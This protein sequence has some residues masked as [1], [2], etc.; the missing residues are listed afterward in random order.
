MLLEYSNFDEVFVVY[1]IVV[2]I[3]V[4]M[5]EGPYAPWHEKL[6]EREREDGRGWFYQT[7]FNLF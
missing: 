6:K 4:T 3:V 7:T 5:S 2:H 1:I